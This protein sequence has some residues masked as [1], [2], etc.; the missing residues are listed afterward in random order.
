MNSKAISALL[1]ALVGTVV[2]GRPTNAE[3]INACLIT[4]TDTNPFYI[5]MKAGAEKEAA[6]LGIV[7]KTY[8]GKVD[9]DNESQVAAIETCIADGARG[10]LI[11]PS[12]TKAIVPSVKKARDAGILVIALGRPLDP[13]DAADQTFATDSVEAG[14][15]VG[16]WVAAVQDN[17]I[18]EGRSAVLN[19]GQFASYDVD[20]ARDTGFQT[21]L[22]INEAGTVSCDC[23]CR[24]TSCKD[25][26]KSCKKVSDYAATGGTTEGGRKA[27]DDL[28]RMDP[29]INV[30]FATNEPVA[31]GA[32]QALEAIG[33]QHDVVI[34]STDGECAGISKVDEG[35]ISATSLEFPDRMGALGVA[36]IRKWS[37][38]G[39]KPKQTE[40]KNFIDTGVSLV[41]NKP[42]NGVPSIDTKEA[43][44]LCGN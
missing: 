4:R 3:Q 34:V 44:A 29:A 22:A 39:E 13:I 17:K 15:L 33:K 6:E 2:L 38:S 24:Q 35:V 23:D 25:R 14:R 10:I 43:A 32:Y 42:V 27:A 9:G 12:D 11:A 28:L 8:A 16:S 37:D 41:T 26:C 20:L 1:L 36:A 31:V 40:G 21:G 5:K 7:L 19:F 18:Q 30:I